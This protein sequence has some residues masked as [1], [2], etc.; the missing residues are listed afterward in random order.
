MNKLKKKIMKAIAERWVSEV[1]PKTYNNARRH[2]SG[3]GLADF[4][5]I[6]LEEGVDWNTKNK[7]LLFKEIRRVMHMARTDLQRVLVVIDEIEEEENGGQ[8]SED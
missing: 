5:R 4:V 6:E 8:D 7:D 3:D 1:F 2:S